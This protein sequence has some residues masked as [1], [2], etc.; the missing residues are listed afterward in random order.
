[1]TGALRGLR[2]KNK[3]GFMMIKSTIIRVDDMARYQPHRGVRWV[4]GKFLTKDR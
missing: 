3:K 1:M 2:K 4:W